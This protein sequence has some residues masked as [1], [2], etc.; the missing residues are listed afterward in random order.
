MEESKAKY[1]VER[2]LKE[3]NQRLEDQFKIIQFECVELKYKILLLRD[4]ATNL[5]NS[6][7]I[8]TEI[9][10]DV[11]SELKLYEEFAESLT[12]Q[13]LNIIENYNKMPM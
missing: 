11:L 13:K 5:V 9:I 10:N 1:E 12:K 2:L 7:N 8:T 3:H 6:V 4:K